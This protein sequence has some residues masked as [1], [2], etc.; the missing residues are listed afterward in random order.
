M[1]SRKPKKAHPDVDDGKSNLSI[2]TE[3]L[4]HWEQSLG[5][6]R[7]SLS[8]RLWNSLRGNA[9]SVSGSLGLMGMVLMAVYMRGKLQGSQGLVESI[10]DMVYAVSLFGSA[11]AHLFFVR[12][13]SVART[14]LQR[15][16]KVASQLQARQRSAAEECKG[17]PDQN[18][19]NPRKP[20]HC[21]L[22]SLRAVPG[23]AQHGHH[24]IL[25]ISPKRLAIQ[26]RDIVLGENDRL[27][28]EEH[29]VGDGG[30]VL[31]EFMLIPLANDGHLT[32]D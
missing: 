30:Y 25:A 9:F 7:L 13:R 8:G 21:S 15:L 14:M 1:Q 20:K 11:T 24:V 6:D 10:V 28:Y 26:Q 5:G 32:Q 12:N 4:M 16:V 2:L 22:N 23:L 3:L 19:A 18:W 27:N 31:T 17:P 29:L